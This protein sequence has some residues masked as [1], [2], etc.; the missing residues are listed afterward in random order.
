MLGKIN[1]TL[2]IIL[3]WT[4]GLIMSAIVVILFLGVVLRYVF[5]APLFWSEEVAVLGLI[6]ITFLGG[7]ILIRQDKN[8][9]ITVFCDMCRTPVSRWM[10]IVSDALV[11]IMLWVMIDQSWELTQRLAFSTTPALRLKESWFGWAMI[12][13]FVIML[14]YQVQRI[15]ALLFKKPA[16][17][18]MAERDSECVL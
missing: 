3:D 17:P 15:I 2:A 7:A 5:N 9:C 12:V 13:G 10:K 16:F 14:Y 8:V 11:V 18:E 1:R 6:W 4:I